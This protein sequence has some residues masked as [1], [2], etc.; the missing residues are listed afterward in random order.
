MKYLFNV[1]E[2][3]KIRV[4]IDADAACECDDQYAIVYALLS[5][6]LEVKGVI[7]THFNDMLG[8][9]SMIASYEMCKKVID[10]MELDYEVPVFKGCSKKMEPGA[11]LEECEGVD[12]IISEA[13]RDDPRPLYYLGLGPMTDLATAL[14]KEPTIEGKFKNVIWIGGGTIMG[15]IQEFNHA[16]DVE[17]G[18]AIMLSNLPLSSVQVESYIGIKVGLAEFQKKVYPYGKIGKFLFEYMAKMNEVYAYDDRM[19]GP[20]WP[21]GESWFIADL[22]A[23]GLALEPHEYCYSIEPPEILLPQGMHFP[24]PTVRSIKVFKTANYRYMLEDFFAKLALTYG[25]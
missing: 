18:N 8:E 19:A 6:R 13:L 15:C 10:L 1:P 24:V 11:P 16:N 23:V 12:F 22:I 20:D 14:R 5:P 7:G 3:R 21:V 25:D 17:A 2:N 4:I 9:G